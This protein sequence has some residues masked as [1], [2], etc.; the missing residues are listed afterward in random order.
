MK[1]LVI[2]PFQDQDFEQVKEIYQQG[3]NTKI[4]T[5]ET[6][7]PTFE[8]WESKFRKNLRFVA[9]EKEIICGWVAL[10]S[11]SARK[12][13][14]GVCEV[15]LYVA[16]E[17]RGQGIGKL[18]LKKIIS[19][20]EEQG[21]WTLQAGIFPENIGSINL[22]KKFGF[23]EIG[24]REKIGMRDGKWHDNI[25]LERRSKLVGV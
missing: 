8:I 9:T 20:S 18:L 1:E 10:S 22:H 14:E 5:F 6:E 17:F 7:P 25:F 23:R 21:I 11:V 2:R 3:I 16:K 4:A 19:E 12:V 13:Y 24:Y 15:S